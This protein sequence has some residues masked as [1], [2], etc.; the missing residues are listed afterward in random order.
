MLGRGWE[1]V[2]GYLGCVRSYR[3]VMGGRVPI[4]GFEGVLGG[5]DG[6]VV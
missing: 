5:L 6:R 3:R 2:R 1:G 4:G